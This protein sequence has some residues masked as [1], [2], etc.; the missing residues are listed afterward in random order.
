MRQDALEK[1]WLKLLLALEGLYFS[2]DI[3]FIHYL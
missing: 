3:I 2:P 1:I